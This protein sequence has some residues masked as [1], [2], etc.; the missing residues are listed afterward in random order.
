M[1]MKLRRRGFT[2]IELLVVIAIIAILIALLLPAVQQAREAARRTQCKNNFK[3]LGLAIHNYH[4]VYNA[5]PIGCTIAGTNG[6]AN[7]VRRFSAHLGL[8][9]FVEQQNLYQTTV[10]ELALLSSN[11]TPWNGALTV[12]NS[13]LTHLLCPSDSDSTVESDRPKTNYLFSR[14]DNGWDQ[15]QAWHGNGGNGIRGFFLGV[16]DDGQGGGPRRFRD[17]TDGLSNTIAMGERITAK[18]GGSSILDGTTT[19]AVA[20]GGRDNPSLCVASVSGTGVYTT[21]GNASGSALAGVRAF[22]G[23]PPFTAVNTVIP[24]NGPSCKNGNDNQHDRDGLFTM[25]S[26]HT[27][28]VQVLMGDG[29]VRAVSENIDSGD[30]TAAPVASGESPYGVWGALGTVRGREVIGEF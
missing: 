3:Q 17:I 9:P 29:S 15:N 27:G 19:T 8:L 13:K 5:V 22:D 6:G 2:L 12:N 10:G 1:N 25:S 7:N 28:I 16:R 4:D 20:N 21:V 24:P 30:L 11:G 14:G 23:A 18:S 26:Q